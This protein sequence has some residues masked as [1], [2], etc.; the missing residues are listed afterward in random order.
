PSGRDALSRWPSRPPAATRAL[1]NAWRWS[2]GLRWATFL[3]PL[4]PPA[5][6]ALHFIGLR[7]HRERSNRTV[8]MELWPG[9]AEARLSLGRSFEAPRDLSAA[10]RRI[11]VQTIIPEI[12]AG[13]P[14]GGLSAGARRLPKPRVGS[15]SLSRATTFRVQTATGNASGPA[16]APSA[17]ALRVPQ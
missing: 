13:S 7:D 9:S 11:Q 5:L 12:L 17:C 15:S 8:P 6:A 1:P 10:Q 16:V 14:N 2:S 3:F 4:P